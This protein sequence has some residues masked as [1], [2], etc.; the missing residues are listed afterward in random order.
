[1][2]EGEAAEK[3]TLATWPARRFSTCRYI[4]T[5]W[6]AKSGKSP[7]GAMFTERKGEPCKMQDSGW[8]V[9]LGLN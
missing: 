2:F 5:F 6:L 9:D 1:M 7:F 3:F 4:C 8:M